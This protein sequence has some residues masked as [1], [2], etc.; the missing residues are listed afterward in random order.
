M[1]LSVIWMSLDQPEAE[2]LIAAR[3]RP[4]DRM[5]AGRRRH[6]LLVRALVRQLAA[7]TGHDACRPISCDA[8]GKPHFAAIGGKKGPALSLTH[9]GRLAVAALCAGGDLGI[10]LEC[11]R[12]RDFAALAARAFGP[13]EQA[14]V[15]ADGENAFYRIWT[16]REAFAKAT[17]HGLAEATDGADRFARDRGH[18]PWTADA[19]W[20][21]ASPACVPG[22]SLAIA[23]RGA[24]TPVG[25]DCRRG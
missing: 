23:V 4:E 19:N 6:S 9:S 22:H 24:G 20:S 16:L 11:R 1:N 14:A 13:R 12:P 2:G 7:E 17:G 5:H 18:A 3:A 15:A 25:L 10:D 8:R 21:F